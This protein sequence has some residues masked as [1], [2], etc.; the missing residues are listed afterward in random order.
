MFKNTYSAFI[1]LVRKKDWE[2]LSKACT[3]ITQLRDYQK[4]F[5]KNY[6]DTLKQD[7]KLGGAY[8]LIGLYHYAK[9]IDVVTTYMLNGSNGASDVRERVR[10]HFD[11]SIEAAEKTFNIEMSLF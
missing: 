5:E 6:L 7:D 1:H 10:F 8:E 2:D 3:I 9:A 11:K 4:F